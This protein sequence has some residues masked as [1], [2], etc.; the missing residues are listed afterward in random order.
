MRD[1][2]YSEIATIQGMKNLP[3]KPD[4]AIPAGRK[5]C[6]N[7]LKPLQ[8]TFGRIAVRS[9]FRSSEVNAYGCLHRLSCASNEK[10]R[11]RHTWDK[12]SADAKIGAVTNIV[13]PW[14]VDRLDQGVTWTA[15][16]WDP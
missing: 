4:L 7:L 2:L 14:L 6:E 3:D 13:V 1:L 8:H 16:A 11:A 12:R 9:A 15:M 5:L 10:N